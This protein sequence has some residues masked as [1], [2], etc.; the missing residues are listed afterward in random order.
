[1]A[2]LVFTPQARAMS[3]SSAVAR[4]ARPI[5]VLFSTTHSTTSSAAV[6]AKMSSQVVWM[7]TLPTRTTSTGKRKL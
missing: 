4:Q 6:R 5:L 3:G 1:M 2:E 7:V